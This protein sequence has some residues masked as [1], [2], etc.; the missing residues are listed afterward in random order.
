MARHRARSIILRVR[1]LAFAALLVAAAACHR[2]KPA[3]VAP[4]TAEDESLRKNEGDLIM[5]RGALQ[6]ERKKLADARAEIIERRSQ[7]GHDSAGQAALDEEEKK[8]LAQRERSVD[9]RVD[10]QRQARRAAQD[11]RRSRQ[12][13]HAGGG[14]RAGRRSARARGAARAVGGHARKGSGRARARRGGARDDAGGARGDAGQ[15]RARHLRRGGDAGE[16]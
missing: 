5:Q 3:D 11:A 14:D 13:R 7:L 6:R 16:D 1:R 4:I 10:G 15:A 9:A 12:A 8:L 2:N